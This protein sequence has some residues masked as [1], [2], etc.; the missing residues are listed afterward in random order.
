MEGVPPQDAGEHA[1]PYSAVLFDLDGTL[2]DSADDIAE[3]VNRTL[4]ERSLQRQPVARIHGWIG[5]GVR[6]LLE[7]ALHAAH[8]DATVDE[9]L[10]DLMRHY[11]AT[12]LLH[13]RL[14][15]GAE[16]TLRALRA[17]GVLL[18]LCTNKPSRFL[19]PLM[20]HLGVAD[21]FDAMV[22]GD[23]LPQRKPDPRPLLHIAERFA[24]APQQCLMVGDSR[25]DAEAANAAHMPLALVDYGYHRGFDVRAAGAVAVLHDLRELLTLAAAPE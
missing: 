10:P 13:A 11:A 21:C 5:E 7:R 19:L 18:A 14:Y 17:Q 1:F 15:P 8:S 23:S 16:E 3:A 24:L 9:V 6:V 20:R 12:L 4:C 25:T 2:V 22:G